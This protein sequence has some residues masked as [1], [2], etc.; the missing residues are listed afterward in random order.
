MVNIP[1]HLQSL[2]LGLIIY[3]G[4]LQINKAGNTRLAF[5]LSIDPAAEALGEGKLE[6]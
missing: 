2:I 5:K 4:W 3:D 6:Y 1:F